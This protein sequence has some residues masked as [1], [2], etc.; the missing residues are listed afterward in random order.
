[1]RSESEAKVVILA[2]SLFLDIIAMIAK[3]YLNVFMYDNFIQPHFYFLPELT[4]GQMWSIVFALSVIF[5][6]KDHKERGAEELLKN[7]LNKIFMIVLA[8][9]IA[10]VALKFFL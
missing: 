9:L 3:V 1:M 6:D 10:I 4:T 2:T 8:Y 7:S 5:Y